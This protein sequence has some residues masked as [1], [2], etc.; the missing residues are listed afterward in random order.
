M[1]QDPAMEGWTNVARSSSARYGGVDKCGKIALWRGGQMW[2]DR[3]PPAMDGR[4][5]VPRSRSVY[6]LLSNY[7][8][9]DMRHTIQTGPKVCCFE[10]TLILPKSRIWDPPILWPLIKSNLMLT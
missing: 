7:P 1:W 8:Q 9:H 6:Y 2:Q 10:P 3:A 4:T 5:N